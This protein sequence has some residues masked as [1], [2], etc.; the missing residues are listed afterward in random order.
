MATGKK[1]RIRLSVAMIVRDEA[2]VL[3]ASIES[4]RAIADEV[5]VY[6]TGSTDRTPEIARR[7][8]A[9]VTRGVWS[10]DFSAARNRT[11]ALCTGQWILWLDAGERLLP[12]TAAELRIFVD[13]QASPDTAY[14]V[15]VEI[16]PREPGN[17]SEQVAQLRLLPN[18]PLLRYEGRLRETVRGALH[19]AGY[20]VGAAPGRITRHPRE[21]DPERKRRRAE[22]NLQLIAL[23]AEQCGEYTPRLL[24]ALGD[25]Y[26]DVGDFEDAR[27]AFLQAV[28]K[29]QPRSHDLLEAYY[30]LLAAMNGTA[31]RP[32]MLSTCMEALEAFPLD[33]QLLMAMGNYLQGERRYELAARA[34]ELAVRHGQVALEAWHLT[35]LAEVAAS[36]WCLTLRLQGRDAAARQ[37]L[38]ET[39]ALRPNSDR[40]RSHLLDLLVKEGLEPEA[41]ELFDKLPVEAVHRA[42]MRDAV[43]GA[44]R[45]ACGDWTAA[46]GYLQSAYVAGCTDPFC[47]RWLATT[48]LTKGQLEAAEPV[49]R[50]WQQLDPDNPE[51]KAYLAMLTTQDEPVTPSPSGHPLD[52]VR[53]LRVD[54]AQSIVVVPVSTPIISQTTSVDG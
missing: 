31:D 41:L 33:A 16:P 43:R 14:A 39:L 26:S 1:R 47:L 12:A 3:A 18:S 24:L 28:S 44:C 52:P 2:D 6:D 15:Y 32:L 7:L 40:L 54:P 10:D 20:T 30:G 48:L 38:E 25:S 37:A 9:I 22:R 45:A 42:A 46:L 4:I 27:D 29:S 53:R 19:T 35:E 36:C 5:V 13:E 49:L 17:S 50:H 51:M 8:G 21:H 11:M 34:F 23:E